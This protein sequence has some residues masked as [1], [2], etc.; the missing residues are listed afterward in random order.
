MLG[1]HIKGGDR[2]KAINILETMKER[3]IVPYSDTF[4]VLISE[5]LRVCNSS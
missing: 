4:Y 2:E 5:L 1:I 3:N